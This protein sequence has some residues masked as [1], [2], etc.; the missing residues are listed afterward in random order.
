MTHILGQDLVVGDKIKRN[1]S[2]MAV[3]EVIAITN[4]TDHAISW[5]G[6]II[7]WCDGSTVPPNQFV[8]LKTLNTTKLKKA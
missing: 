4:R 7:K 1:I 3:I 5:T 2:S 8:Y 6:K